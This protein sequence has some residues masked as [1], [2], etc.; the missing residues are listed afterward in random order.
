MSNFNKKTAF[1]KTNV[2]QESQ[3]VFPYHYIPQYEGGY[4][5]QHLY[6]SWG[7]Q[8][9]GGIQL[10]LNLLREQEFDSLLDI[11]CGDGR[12][13]SEINRQYSDKC[14]LGVDYSERAI[15]MAKALNPELRYKCINICGN[16]EEIGL[17]DIVTLIEVLEHIPVND[18]DYFVAAISRY[19]KSNGILI[20]TV[21]HKNKALQPKHYQHFDVQ[22]LSRMLGGTFKIES[23]IYFDKASYLFTAIKKIL[24]ENRF[25]ILNN[26][27]LLNSVFKYYKRHFFI[28]EENVCGRICVTA[29]KNK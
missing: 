29:K 19:L 23:F 22:S 15:N 3:Y 24:L 12:F 26:S 8:Y 6:W 14:L 21:P 4:F 28:C 1:N 17:F 9:L 2:T 11:G 16:N 18:A 20:I 7:I 27:F 5:S 13:I 25:F 10:V